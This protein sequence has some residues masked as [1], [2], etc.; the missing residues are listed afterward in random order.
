MPLILSFQ[1]LLELSI[2]KCRLFCKLH[3]YGNLAGAVDIALKQPA[4]IYPDW[5]PGEAEVGFV[6]LVGL[7]QQQLQCWSQSTLEWG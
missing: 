2:W 6:S 1:P 3:Q 7:A 5:D 4:N